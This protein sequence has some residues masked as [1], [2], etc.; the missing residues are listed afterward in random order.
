MLTL[1]LYWILEITVELE[2]DFN[3]SYCY[4]KHLYFEIEITDFR[5]FI[6]F[7]DYHFNIWSSIDLFGMVRYFLRLLYFEKYFWTFLYNYFI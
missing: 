4:F 7:S 2:I 1:G 6:E 3:G 5:A